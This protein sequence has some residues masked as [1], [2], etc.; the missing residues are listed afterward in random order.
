MS[1]ASADLTHRHTLSKTI[2]KETGAVVPIVFDGVMLHPLSSRHAL[3]KRR[4]EIYELFGLEES[5]DGKV[6]SLDVRKEIPG[7][8]R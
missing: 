8:Q 5:A 2:D 6:A 3:I 7:M 1:S 4:K